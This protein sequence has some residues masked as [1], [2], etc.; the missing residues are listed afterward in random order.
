MLI[1]TTPPSEEPID[2]ATARLQVRLTADDSTAE[3]A[4]FSIWIAAARRHAETLTGRSFVTQAWRLVLDEF[5]GGC[6][7][8]ER[9][10]VTSI[11]SLTYRDM[12][13]ATQTIAWAA[14]AN[15]IQRSTDGRLV[16]DL[17]DDMAR[18]APAYGR[19]WP[20]ALPEIGAVAVAY[21]AG[22][23]AASAVPEGIKHWML[24]R[25]ARA[26]ETREEPVDGR[27]TPS[28]L[29]G[30]LDSYTVSRP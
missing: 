27:L 10:P 22:Y 14:A 29:D 12:A 6:I 11:T 23:G 7:E 28:H 8:L 3:N 15:G 16:A 5:C 9:G 19:T 21:T 24:L 1:L 25:V 20:D 2:L 17:S 26:Y 4:L 30:M 18:I 13:G